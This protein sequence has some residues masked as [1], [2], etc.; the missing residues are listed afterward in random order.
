MILFTRTSDIASGQMAPAIGF[1][2]KVSSYIETEYGRRVEV[3]MPVAGNPFRIHW[4]ASF[5]SLEKFD[6]LMTELMQDPK[7]VDMI[8]N[9]SACF[10]PGTAQDTLTKTI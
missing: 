2:K 8:V 9:A 5:E 6:T 4:T 1:A 3:S 7:Y 10:I